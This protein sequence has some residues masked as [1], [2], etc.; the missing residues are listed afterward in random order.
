[1]RRVISPV[2]VGFGVFLIVAAALVRFYAYPTLATAPADQDSSTHL[3][4]VGA[5]IFNSDPEVLAPETTDLS[6]LS[7]TVADTEADAP[8]GVSVWHNSTT[9]RRDDG[10]IFQQTR[11]RAA[12]DSVTGAGV[13]CE[14]CGT[15]EEVAEGERVDVTFDGQVYKFPF[16]TQPKDYEVWDGTLGEATTATYEG[17]EQVEGVDVYKFVQVIEPTVVETRELPGSIFGSDEESVTAEMIYSMTRT[18]Y[19]EPVTG[20]PVDR[21]EERTQE[22]VYDG[23]AVPAFNGTV[24]YTDDQVASTAEDVGGQA[25][26]LGGMRVL[27]PLLMLVL[28]GVLIVAG[29]LLGRG[30]HRSGKHD[31]AADTPDRPMVSA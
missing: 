22:L 28:G 5:E 30:T 6:I 2:L 24:Q 14:E 16:D 23:T 29:L 12:F 27:H 9:V 20:A 1:M 26:L 11:E 4:A 15:W 31:A 17:E 21:V 25:P 7:V 8:D 3:E 18:Q 13:E 19:I 10:S